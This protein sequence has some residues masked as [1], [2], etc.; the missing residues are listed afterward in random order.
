MSRLFVLAV[1]LATAALAGAADW[2]QYRGPNRDNVSPDRG[3]LQS[4][5]AKGP[6]LA[7]KS[8]DVG[9]G[10]S[11]VS[12]V[13]GRVYTMGN[14]DGTAY[15]FA[16][17]R[18]NGQV[19][20]EAKV[21]A[22]GKGG[23][24]RNSYPG[25]RCTPPSD[26]NLVFALGPVGDL[27][28]VDASKGERVWHKDLR[29]D[30]KGSYGGWEYSESPLIDGDRLICTPGGS[31]ATLLALD[32]KSGTEVWKTPLGGQAGYASVVVSEACGVKQYVTLTPAGLV[33]VRA[34]DGKLL[35]NYKRLANRIANIPT[36]IVKGDQVF[37][38]S[39]Y[40]TGAALLTLSKNGD[41]IAV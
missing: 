9:Q 1:C 41:D 22:G 7:W 18:Q 5:P 32:K 3:L 16:L 13:G 17:N 39:G 28:C 6:K 4:W 26:G 8:G 33:G 20:W 35:W 24:G 37:A 15:L 31:S 29:A 14:R 36:P 38:T 21:G 11:S 40:R 10:Y 34:S 27:V 30:Y 12:V 23:R 2:P 25:T 19:V